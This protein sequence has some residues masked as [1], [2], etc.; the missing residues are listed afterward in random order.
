VEGRRLVRRLLLPVMLL[1]AVTISAAAITLAFGDR[2]ARGQAIEPGRVVLAPQQLVLHLGDTVRVNGA[3]IG[4][5]V[6]GRGGRPTIECHRLVSVKGSYGTF[7]SERTT[8]VA[9]F[10]STNVAKTIF[11]A[12]HGGGWRTCGAGATASRAQGSG[13]R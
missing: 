13:C 12:K 7:V 1:C 2:N 6:T 3:D 5:Q 11:T 8:I 10:R 9:R 4:C